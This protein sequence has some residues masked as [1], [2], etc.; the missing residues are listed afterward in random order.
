MNDFLTDLLGML[1]IVWGGQLLYILSE[2]YERWHIVPLVVF[3]LFAV[4]GMNLIEWY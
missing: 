3:V 4:P 2:K 1:L